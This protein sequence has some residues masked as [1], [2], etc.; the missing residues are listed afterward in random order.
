[1]PLH[2]W[3]S[4]RKLLH[5][6]LVPVLVLLIVIASLVWTARSAISDL[7]SS[8]ARI[9]ELVADRL[10][11]TIAVQSALGD[12]MDTEANAIVASSREA[13]DAANA[14]L[15]ANIAKALSAIDTLAEAYDDPA[16]RESI[17]AIKS[18][19][20]EYE[21]VAQTTVQLARGFDTDGAIRVSIDVGR[22]VRQKLTAA[23]GE[24]VEQ[25][26]AETREA[27]RRATALSQQVMTRLYT[28]AG[29]GLL[30]A[31]GLLGSILLFF[32]VRPL[33]RLTSEMTSIAAGD[34]TV[35][36]Q[37]TGRSDEVG[38]L[39][40]ALQVFKS[41]GL[42]MRRL[43]EESDAQK[44]QM[45]ADR[46]S[47]MLALADQFDANVQGVVQAVSQAARQLQSNAQ[48]MTGA[49]E[50]T[51]EQASSVAAATEQASANVATVAA[52]SEQLGSSIGEIGRQV[53]GAATVARD[54]VAE[55]ERTNAL[56]ERLASAA[57]KIGDVVNLIQNIASQTNLLALNATIEA[58]R[59]GEAGKGFAVVAGEVKALATQTSQATEEI[60]SQITEIQAITEGTVTAIRNIARTIADV[61]AIAGAIAAA[62]EEQTAATHEIGRNIQ[63][64]AQGT[65]LVSGNIGGVSQSATDVREAAAEVLDAANSLSR[66]S[67][68]L[69]DE[70]HGFI[71]RVRA[72]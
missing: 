51:T 5:K 56:V 32:V 28:V 12:A 48:T 33:H 50:T 49:A 44:R 36:I 22:P 67:D 25:S 45:E 31:F 4:N 72:G 7:T 71:A 69:R 9:T 2:R 61:D 43:Q 23:L 35:A 21:R 6:I 42:D 58:A 52:A 16:E 10:G 38:L 18:I 19:V 1:M 39:A 41:N 34:L 14:Q 64:A 65:R 29:A 47:A 30:F 37:G 13:I 68:L 57:Q 40:R 63:Q 60:A 62:V 20:G 3:F 8:T 54:A 15:T 46:R 17:Q 27:E 55:G 59:A 53:N 26:M 70:I 66:D 11:A 24:R